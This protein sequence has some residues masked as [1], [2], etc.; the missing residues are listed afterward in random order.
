MYFYFNFI[1]FLFFYIFYQAF[2]A[3]EAT[4]RRPFLT[5][6]RF[7]LEL[8]DNSSTHI[9]SSQRDK[10]FVTICHFNVTFSFI[11]LPSVLFLAACVHIT[12]IC[13]ICCCFSLGV[14]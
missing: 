13:A 6:I 8:A 11:L 4:A 14:E 2:P 12:S 3:D 7:G 10:V 5:L 9:Y 1:S